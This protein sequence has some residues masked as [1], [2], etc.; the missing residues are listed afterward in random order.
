MTTEVGTGPVCLPG[1]NTQVSSTRSTHEPS[2]ANGAWWMCPHSTRS[3]DQRLIHSVTV[4]SPKCRDPVQL[5]NDSGGEWYTH[6][7]RSATERPT[8][9]ST[10]SEPS[11]ATGR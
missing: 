4:G 7:Q 3:G 6:T 1:L 8:S 10:L 9:A 2:G 11:R 5:S